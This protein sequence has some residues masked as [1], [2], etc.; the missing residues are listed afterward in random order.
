M[1]SLAERPQ[2]QL[3]SELP[4]PKSKNAAAQL[5]CTTS[6]D[7]LPFPPTRHRGANPSGFRG[8]SGSVR[9]GF[10]LMN[11][12]GHHFHLST[13]G[14]TPLPNT[15]VKFSQHPHLPSGPTI[16]SLTVSEPQLD[17]LLLPLN[18]C[19][20]WLSFQARPVTGLLPFLHQSPPSPAI[21][22]VPSNSSPHVLLSVQ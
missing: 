2:L 16:F 21:H 6:P 20:H 13:A 18:R 4:L 11:D 17:T 12:R 5:A 8:S 3:V 7:A 22:Y 15:R 9:Y 1:C 10:A 14:S 19:S